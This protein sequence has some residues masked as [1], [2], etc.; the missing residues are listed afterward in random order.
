VHRSSR[1][2]FGR[3]VVILAREPDLVPAEHVFPVN[4]AEEC[5]VVGCEYQLGAVPVDVRRLKLPYQGHGQQ[6]VQAR[7][8]LIDQE[9]PAI[10]E[11]RERAGSELEKPQGSR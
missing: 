5:G 11:N 10:V 2:E 3:P 6:W 7:V 9:Q 1:Q 8:D 4:A